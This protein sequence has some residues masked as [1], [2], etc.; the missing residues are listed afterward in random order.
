MLCLV[1][2]GDKLL[3]SRAV[4]EA[5]RLEDRYF[6]GLLGRVYHHNAEERSRLLANHIREDRARASWSDRLHDNDAYLG[7]KP[8]GRKHQLVQP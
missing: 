5:T 6:H 8:D 1:Q 3:A 2:G 7:L 4:K